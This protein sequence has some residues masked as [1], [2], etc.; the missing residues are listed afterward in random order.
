MNLDPKKVFLE[1]VTSG[2]LGCKV[3]YFFWYENKL[4]ASSYDKM[5]WKP[6]LYLTGLKQDDNKAFLVDVFHQLDVIA[7]EY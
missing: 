1:K 3:I 4:I 6:S 5:E 7:Q 2:F